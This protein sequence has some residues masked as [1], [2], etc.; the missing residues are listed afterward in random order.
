VRIA[1]SLRLVAGALL[2]AAVVVLPAQ[3]A[4]ESPPT[5]ENEGASLHWKPSEATIENGGAVVFKNTSSAVPHG[6]RWVSVPE[7]K[8]PG[9]DAS[10]PVEG[11]AKS[12]GTSWSGSCKFI[13]SGTYVFWCTVHGESMKGTIAV[14]PPGEKGKETTPTGTTTGTTTTTTTPLPPGGPAGGAGA[15]VAA[16]LSALRLT[17]PQHGARVRG[18]LVIPSAAA[19]GTLAVDLFATRPALSA[20]AR[21]V[22]IGHLVKRYLSAGALRFSIKPEPRAVRALRRRGVLKLTLVA[23]LTPAGAGAS[24]V[25]RRLTL[26]R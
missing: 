1:K 17:V 19:G 9:C 24:S 15:T 14:K 13:A 2:G 23:R 22:R 26:R 8:T 21:K 12:S 20:A 6:V 18:S 7:A 4:S 3:A 11:A 25:S 5:I 10:V 16:A